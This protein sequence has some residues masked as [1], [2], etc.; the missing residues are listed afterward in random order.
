MECML[1]KMSE[2][3]LD[4][5]KLLLLWSEGHENISFKVDKKNYTV[6]YKSVHIK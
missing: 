4:I 1:Y 3:T 6:L 2:D 5:L